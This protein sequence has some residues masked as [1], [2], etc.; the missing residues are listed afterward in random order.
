MIINGT[1]YHPETPAPV[2][3]ALEAARN[4]NQRIRLFYG[5]QS[6]GRDWM[7]AHDTMGY[8]HRS[9]GEIKAPILLASK[10]SIGGGAILTRC[11]VRITI[12]GIETYRH[13]AYHQ[14]E[15]TLRELSE[16]LIFPY[17]IYAADRNIA[18]FKTMLQAQRYIA[19]IKGERNS[20]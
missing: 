6:T 10:R 7:E 9:S 3:A 4:N 11:V 19:F 15:L 5:D 14:D 17:Q 18:N 16:E 12:G 1:T 2:A 8:V 20:K 13:P